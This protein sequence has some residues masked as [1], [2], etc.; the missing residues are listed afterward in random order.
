MDPEKV[1]RAVKSTAIGHASSPKQLDDATEH[2][3]RQLATVTQLLC[4]PRC[5]HSTDSRL[6]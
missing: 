1:E 2:L 5:C 3:I 6:G 4:K